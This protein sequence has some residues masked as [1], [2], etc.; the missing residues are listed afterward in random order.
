MVLEC[1]MFSNF[2]EKLDLVLSFQLR[3]ESCD[4]NQIYQI[5]HSEVLLVIAVITIP[6]AWFIYI[7]NVYIQNSTQT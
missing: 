3:I 4:Q 7:P 5:L 2:D 1:N 6:L